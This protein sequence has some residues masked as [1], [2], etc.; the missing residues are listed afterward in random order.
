MVLT[1]RKTKATT[2]ADPLRDDNKKGK[3]K[4]ATAKGNSNGA[5][6]AGRG[7]R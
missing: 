4:K 6:L 3:S 2:T 1:S 5:V 7:L